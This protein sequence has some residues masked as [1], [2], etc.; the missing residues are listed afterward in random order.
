MRGRRTRFTTPSPNL[1]AP[2]RRERVVAREERVLL[3]GDQFLLR[4]HFARKP[5]QLF[6]RTFVDVEQ[7]VPVNFDLLLVRHIFSEKG[8]LS[9]ARLCC[10]STARHVRA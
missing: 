9:R 7:R 8:S 6:D 5:V 2:F 1:L 4:D 3:R 10:F